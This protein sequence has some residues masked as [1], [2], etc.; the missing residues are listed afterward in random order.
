VIFK[1]LTPDASGK[2]NIDAPEVRTAL[3]TL[4]KRALLRLPT[5]TEIAHLRQLYR[6]VDA[7][8]KPSPAAKWMQLS[9]FAV[10]TTVE[11]LFY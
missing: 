8:G 4:Y 3:E 10:M 1:G 9:C 2:I 7:T 11:A 5:D 6:D